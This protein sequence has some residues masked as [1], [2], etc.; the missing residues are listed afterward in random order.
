MYISTKTWVKMNNSSYSKPFLLRYGYVFCY[1]ICCS[2]HSIVYLAQ[3]PCL[4]RNLANRLWHCPYWLYFF[5]IHNLYLT[6]LFLFLSICLLSSLR[7]TSC[8]HCHAIDN[9][10]YHVKNINKSENNYL[11][12]KMELQKVT[13]ISMYIFKKLCASCDSFLM[14]SFLLPSIQ[15][16]H[17]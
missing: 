1:T 2:V 8:I 12:Q 16:T 6:L 11:H 17:S 9:C 7:Y 5:K 10:H 13:Y 4:L 15:S 3:I 14:Y